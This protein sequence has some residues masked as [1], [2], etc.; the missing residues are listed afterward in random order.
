M[1][2]LKERERQNEIE[3][4]ITSKWADYAKIHAREYSNFQRSIESTREEDDHAPK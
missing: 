3:K 4:K 1:Q 2:I